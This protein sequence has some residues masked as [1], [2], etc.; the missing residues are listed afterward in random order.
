MKRG[1][2]VFQTKYQNGEEIRSTWLWPWN[3][4]WR[5]T[6]WFEY[7]RNCSWDGVKKNK[8]QKKNMQWAA[9]FLRGQRWRP[10]WSKLTGRLINIEQSAHWEHFVIW[11]HVLYK[12]CSP[13]ACSTPFNPSPWSPPTVIPVSTSQPSWPVVIFWGDF[14]GF[15]IEGA[16][17]WGNATRAHSSTARRWVGETPRV[18]SLSVRVKR[19]GRAA[20]PDLPQE[21]G[22]GTLFYWIHV[23]NIYPGESHWNSTR[24][25]GFFS[26]KLFPFYIPFPDVFI[27]G[28]LEP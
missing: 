22:D 7:L 25:T 11:M 9:A 14:T 20:A 21:R 15:E 19:T 6:G 2:A 12:T 26:V 16:G 17:R 13:C 1:S 4:C 24:W 28:H 10:D 5:Q 3:D 27:L 18:L 8:K 23:F